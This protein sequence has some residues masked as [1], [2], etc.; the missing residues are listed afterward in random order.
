MSMVR[1]DEIDG[2]CVDGRVVCMNHISIEEWEELE[3]TEL[4]TNAQEDDEYLYFCDRCGGRL[5]TKP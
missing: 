3:E 5:P 2:A 1:I 4:I